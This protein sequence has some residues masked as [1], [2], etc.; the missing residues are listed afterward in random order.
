[1]PSFVPKEQETDMAYVPGTIQYRRRLEK[2]KSAKLAAQALVDKPV[3][4]PSVRDTSLS[5]Q[6]SSQD[7]PSPDAKPSG[8]KPIGTSDS[9]ASQDNLATGDNISDV[10]QGSPDT[11]PSSDAISS[12]VP[13]PSPVTL[14]SAVTQPSPIVIPSVDVVSLRDEPPL[15]SPVQVQA[16]PLPTVS[17]SSDISSPVVDP[18]PVPKRSLNPDIPR[19]AKLRLVPAITPTPSP[20]H[21]YKNFSFRDRD[22]VK[23]MKELT[24]DEWKVYCYLLSVTHEKWEGET[25]AWTSHHVIKEETGV[26]CKRT[27]GLVLESLEAKGFIRR[28]FTGNRVVKMSQYRVFLPCEREGYA[29]KTKIAYTKRNDE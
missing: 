17:A 14:S 21:I 23:Y 20:V 5:N 26:G 27:V 11:I 22:L 28:T 6:F 24:G 2:E 19:L 29:G 18:S 15:P 16:V 3:D 10:T 9:I 8:D 12:G 13:I 4:K 1:M 25:H 7:K